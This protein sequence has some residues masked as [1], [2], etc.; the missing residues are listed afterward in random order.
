[1][2]VELQ[3]KL[4]AAQLAVR[5]VQDTAHERGGA[6]SVEFLEL[7][8]YAVQYLRAAREVLDQPLLA[9]DHPLDPVKVA[10][11]LGAGSGGRSQ[12]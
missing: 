8:H 1:M 6:L 10:W 2:Q 4:A 9:P 5:A 7:L 3:Y 12:G 11:E